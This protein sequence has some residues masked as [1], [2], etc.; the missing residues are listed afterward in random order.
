MISL[1]HINSL[2]KEQLESLGWNWLLGEDT[3][4]YV[5]D[6]MLVLSNEQVEA[7][8]EATNELYEMY[9]KAADFV[10]ENKL[11]SKL[12]ISENLHEIIN[13]TWQKDQEHLHLYGR[14]DLAGGIDGKEIKLIEF[15]AN[16]AT[17]I[18][19][20]A[21]IQS[22]Q[23]LANGYDEAK[24]FNSLYESLVEQ[25]Q[26]LK[27]NNPEKE[28]SILFTC[29]EGSS[30]DD[31][32]LAVLQEAAY[33]AGYYVGFEYIDKVV[34]S[35]EEGVFKYDSITEQYSQFNFMFCLV[36]WEFI[37]EDE[38]ELAKTVSDLIL[39]DKLIV[40]NP[41]YTLVFQSKY[42]LK[43]LWDLFPKHPL[44]LETKEEPLMYTHQVEKVFFGREGA[45]VKIIDKFNQLD[46]F[47]NGEYNHQSKVYQQFVEFP[48]DA[49]GNYYQAGVF[50]TNEACGLGF[51]RGGKILNNL[52]QFCG[53]IIE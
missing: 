46:E 49:E 26:K 37:G 6:K 25:F 51:R 22:A 32:N 48:K 28:A 24:Q 8:Y 20:T 21:V 52:A 15:N 30:E 27:E 40:I 41:P 4:P 39:S 18:P 14:F 17:C 29:L 9:I 23:L 42:I 13:Y 45:N 35:P 10:F 34:F 33:Q 5:T 11:L 47:N 19:E 7:Y 16:T 44:L 43:I 38:P 36:P 50:Y 12:G 53:H 1:K 3:L 2:P 31:S